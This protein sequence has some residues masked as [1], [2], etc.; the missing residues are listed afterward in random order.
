[1]TTYSWPATFGV[2][3]FEM[4]IRHN[5]RVFTGPYT[6]TTQVLDLLGE[7][8]IITLSLKPTIDPIAGAAREAFWDRLKGSA[9]LI[10][11]GHR[12]LKQ[13]LGTMRGTPV[14]TS[15]I[16]QLASTGTITTT[17]GATLR[18]GDMIGLGGQ[19][20]R[21]MADA[22][23]DGS[24]HLV[25][26]FQPRARAAIATGAAVVWDGPTATFMLAPGA[27]G[28]PTAW[29]PGAVEGTSID[30]VEVY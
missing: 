25:I 16:A 22:T 9:N 27:D 4:R 6:P 21:N 30:L 28:A 10:A 11:I 14:V 23:A 8:W 2:T 20:V 15:T 1:M 13:P 18:A 24:G 29:T 26:E 12:K 17:P 7:R 3:R 5:T 19:L